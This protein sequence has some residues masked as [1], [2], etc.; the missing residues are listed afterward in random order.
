MPIAA[1]VI[2]L[3]SLQ[4][5]ISRVESKLITFSTKF[6]IQM[7]NLHDEI[8]DELSERITAITIQNTK[9]SI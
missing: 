9:K 6:E 4:K 3:Y 2:S 8:T 1:D 5:M 7:K